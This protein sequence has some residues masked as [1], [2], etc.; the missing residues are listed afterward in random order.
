MFFCV[1]HLL[2]QR[3]CIIFHGV[4]CT[5]AGKV[6]WTDLFR[7]FPLHSYFG[8]QILGALQSYSEFHLEMPNFDCCFS[9]RQAY[10]APCEPNPAIA[11]LPRSTSSVRTPRSVCGHSG[12]LSPRCHSGP[13]AVAIQRLPVP[14][15]RSGRASTGPCRFAHPLHARAT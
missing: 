8:S 15:P 3:R 7:P 9:V 14:V 1:Y 13:I 11:S 10:F 2:F 5:G 6:T 12:F 4:P